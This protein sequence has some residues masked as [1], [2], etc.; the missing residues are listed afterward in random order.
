MKKIAIL[1]VCILCSFIGFGQN[2]NAIKKFSDTEQEIIRYRDLTNQAWEQHKEKLALSYMDSVKF[3]IVGSYVDEHTFNTVDGRVV[4]LKNLQ[5]PVLL[6][7]SATWCAPCIAEIPA[8]NKVAAEFAEKVTFVV[9][10]HD[11]EDEK[12]AKVVNQY[13][14]LISLV[15]SEQKEANIHALRIA[16]FNHITGYP[17]NYSI[18]LDKKIIA[19]SQGAAVP[20]TS[21]NAQGEKVIVTQARADEL[22]YGKLK[23][24]AQNL[25]K[26]SY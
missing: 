7:T 11:T 4:S 19:Y 24:E 14:N 20:M 13:S 9:L 5:K 8:L 25:I 6:I 10:F 15:A 2:K 3:S 21:F 1:A 23:E 26:L 18:N 22:N 12:L 16:G 17:T